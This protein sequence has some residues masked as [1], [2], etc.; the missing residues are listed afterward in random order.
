MKNF[1]SQIAFA[2]TAA[3]AAAVLG[4]TGSAG[5]VTLNFESGFADLDPVSTIIAPDGN[6]VTFSVG[7]VTTSGN[8]PAFIAETGAPITAFLN[9]DGLSQSAIIGNYFL[10]TDQTFNPSPYNFFIEF[11]NPVSDLSLDLIDYE[12]F[13]PESTVT[14]N[15]FSDN[16]STAIASQT[17]PAGVG[18]ENITN[19]S[20][21]NPTGLISSASI[22]FENNI[23]TGYGIDNITFTTTSTTVPESSSTLGLLALGTLGAGSLLKRK[24]NIQ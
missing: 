9:D 24:S 10:T 6:Q 8:G 18:N 1:I 7:P 15:L 21:T 3:S 5:A 13:S 20:L 19:L 16:F 12:L 22:I 4:V 2:T 23:D 11:A 17:F 14:L